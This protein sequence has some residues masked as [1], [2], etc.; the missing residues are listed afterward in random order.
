LGVMTG[1]LL[2]QNAKRM[3]TFASI[4]ADLRRIAKLTPRQPDFESSVYS[5]WPISKKLGLIWF[6]HRVETGCAN[7]TCGFWCGVK[8][9]CVR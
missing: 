3:Q 4:G 6:Q 9:W 1:R 2:P 7:L 8:G 5:D